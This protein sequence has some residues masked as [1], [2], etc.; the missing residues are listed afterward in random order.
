MNKPFWVSFENW[1]HFFFLNEEFVTHYISFFILA[2]RK[3]WVWLQNQLVGTDP[4]AG[5]D[6]GQEK[7]A[8]EDEM[9]R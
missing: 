5:K 4:D 9:V 1:E 2:A 6:W 7:K 3:L 8:A